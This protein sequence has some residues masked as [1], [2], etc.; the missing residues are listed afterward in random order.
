MVAHST[1]PVQHTT[2]YWPPHGSI[3]IAGYRIR[4]RLGERTY[5]PVMVDHDG[6]EYAVFA[7][8]DA[9]SP[10]G[11]RAKVALFNPGL[12]EVD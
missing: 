9:D 6:N 10:D 11:V 2:H 8:Y 4:R 1:P 12:A 7:A 5:R 3:K